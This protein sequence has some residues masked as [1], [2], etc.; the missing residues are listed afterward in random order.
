MMI[1]LTT[2]NNEQLSAVRQ[3]DGPLLLLAGAGSGKTRVITCR[4]AYLLQEKGVPAE[5]LVA[6]TFTNKAAREMRERV[7]E[8]VGRR[9]VRG[10]TI[11]TFHSLGVRLLREDIERLGYKKNFSIY[12]TAD[13]VRLIRDLVQ[14]GACRKEVR[15]R[16]S[17]LDH[18]RGQKRACRTRG[19]RPPPR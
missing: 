19:V 7:E 9:G 5:A 18:L 1:D 15:R 17:A 13:Q 14:D 12:G 3:T 11:A 4:L 6:V 8:L 2:L 10:M 16:T